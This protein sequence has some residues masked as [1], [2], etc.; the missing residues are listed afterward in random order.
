MIA[1]PTPANAAINSTTA[2]DTAA[3]AANFVAI[4]SMVAADVLLEAQ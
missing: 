2:D 3:A 1:T 4:N